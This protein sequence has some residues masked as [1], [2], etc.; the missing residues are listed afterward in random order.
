ME[1]VHSGVKGGHGG[2]DGTNDGLVAST[3]PQFLGLCSKIS[4]L[5]AIYENSTKHPSHPSI[6]MPDPGISELPRALVKRPSC[7]NGMYM[8]RVLVIIQMI[9]S[10][11]EREIFA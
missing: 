9:I 3:R 5:P 4:R 11:A 10:L 2:G 1:L 7:E 6:L 8:P